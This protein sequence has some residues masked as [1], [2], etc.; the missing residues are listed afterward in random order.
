MDFCNPALE[1][2]VAQIENEL[3]LAQVLITRQGRGYE[4][5]HLEDRL[6]SP[7]DLKP[8]AC[9]DLRSMAQTT[10]AG[11]FRPLKSAPNLPVGWRVVLPGDAELESALNQLYPGAVADWFAV[12]SGYA[13]F[14]G[15]REFTDRQTGMYRVT[16]LLVGERAAQAIRAA[17]HKSFCLKRRLWTAEGQAPDAAEEKSL[18]PCLEPCAVFLEFARTAVR[19]E[20]AEKL[21]FE[22]SVEDAATVQAALESALAHPDPTVR[23]ADFG[24]AGNPRR[25]QLVLEKFAHLS[26]SSQVPEERA[27]LTLSGA[28]HPIAQRGADLSP[29]DRS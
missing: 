23:E 4:L 11:A 24:A 6:R 12:Q 29:P 22:L 26:P 7:G 21:P 25:L 27:Q 2:F 5:R 28:P 3:V 9:P 17:C 16:Q 10:V 15:Y 1:K 14:T 8:V 13:S 18:I 19:I 20:Q